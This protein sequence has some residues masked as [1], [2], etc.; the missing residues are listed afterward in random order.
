MSKTSK[1]INPKQLRLVKIILIALGVG[2][3]LLMISQIVYSN[4][5]N[6]EKKQVE[7][8]FN[9][10]VF[11][12]SLKPYSHM[13]TRVGFG[14]PQYLEYDYISHDKLPSMTTSIQ[15]G[16]E[17]AGFVVNVE[18]C[19][20][21]EYPSC[22]GSALNKSAGVWVGIHIFPPEFRFSPNNRPIDDD[23]KSAVKITLEV[24]KYHE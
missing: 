4:H 6:S 11:P 15:S 16:L 19:Y 5:N 3:G 7:D 8:S 12:S 24:K 21:Q 1:I 22:H 2:F 18:D 10:V 13:W 23:Y 14:E 20:G 17:Q 9:Q